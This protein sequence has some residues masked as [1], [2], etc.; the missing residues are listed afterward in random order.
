M[1]E[2]GL[3]RYTL[4][5]WAC[6]DEAGGAVAVAERGYVGDRWDCGTDHPVTADERVS[7][8]ANEEIT[9]T[10]VNRWVGST[11]T[12]TK[13]VDGGAAA[14]EDWTLTA[15][16]DTG[17][18]TGPSG[19][20]AVTGAF[21]VP[22]TYALAESGGPAGYR[23]DGWTCT[24]GTLLGSTLIVDG[25][26][27][28]ACTVTNVASVVPP[29]P[30]VPPEPPVAPPVGPVDPG[31]GSTAAGGLTLSATGTDPTAPLVLA[32]ALVGLGLLALVTARRR[33]A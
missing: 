6:V 23:S 1:L 9:C 22:G 14:P 12:L 32:G 3:P 24:G 25:E 11:L 18:V 21:V 15:L 29:Q 20:L 17:P 8:V 27:D 10:A 7:I 5:G 31:A 16:G 2:I 19:S 26:Q 13:I 30:P 4:D 28:V 33:R